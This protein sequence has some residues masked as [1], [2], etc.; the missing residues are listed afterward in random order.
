MCGCFDLNS[1]LFIGKKMVMKVLQLQ[2]HDS[3]T[4]WNYT[5][6]E[7]G[8]DRSLG[9]LTV[10]MIESLSLSSSLITVCSSYRALG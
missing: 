10:E 5:N 4:E 2:V 6:G 8:H 9:K 7:A 1:Y 3:D